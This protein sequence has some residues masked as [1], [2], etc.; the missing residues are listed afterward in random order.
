MKTIKELTNMIIEFRDSRDW[1]K[2][3][4]PK[5]LA[6]SLIIE[7]GELFELIQWQSNQEI[8]E[9]IEKISEKVDDEI[10]DVAIYL[11][12]LA[13]ELR[14]DLDKVIPQKI[15]KNISK[16]PVGFLS[17]EKIKWGKAEKSS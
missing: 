5:N 3:H 2:Y 4:T 8:K 15:Q 10:A 1:V 9:E 6:L 13:Y 14:V 16:Y 11:F 7:I 12:L 17:D